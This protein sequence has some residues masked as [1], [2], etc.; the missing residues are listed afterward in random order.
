MIMKKIILIGGYGHDDMGDESQLTAS[1]INLKKFIHDAKFIALSDYRE[2]TLK[3][4]RVETG[5]SINYYLVTRIHPSRIEKLLKLIR[6][7]KVDFFLKSIILLFNACRL[8]KNKKTFFLSEDGMRF[9]KSLRDADLLFNV[10]GGNLNSVFRFGGL[11]SKCLTYIICRIFKVPVIL[12]GQTI[13]PFHCWFDKRVAKFALNRV[14][15]ITL[16]ESFSEKVLKNIGVTKPIIKVTADDSTLL[17]PSSRKKVEEVFSK[18]KIGGHR[19]L[20]GINMIG[21][22]IF[23]DGNVKLGVTRRLLAEI[24]DYLISKH[25]ARVIFISTQYGNTSDDRVA[26]SKVLKLM[27]HKDS[28]H[29]IMGEYDDRLIKGIIGQTDL[30][31]GLRYHFIVFAVNSQVPSI[32]IYLDDYYSLKI[33]GILELVG[34]GKYACDIEKTSFK[35]LKDLVEDI[36][37]NKEIIRRELGERTKQ[38]QN[39]SLLSVKYAA[40]ILSQ[41]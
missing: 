40:K 12:S 15:V 29:I 34:Q 38:L 19:P 28:A 14:N 18:E 23:R 3:H 9:L 22:K 26:A 7:V 33:N 17:T 41:K 21:L 30:V 4:H 13:G 31:I 27:K 24:A 20:I 37:E 16:R 11:Y 5:Y 8:R 25:N 1:L 35:D 36:L 32:G 2:H 6:Y 10:G 39:S